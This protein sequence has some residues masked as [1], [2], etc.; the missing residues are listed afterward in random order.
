MT[1]PAPS[2]T[3]APAPRA[4]VSPVTVLGVAALGFVLLI[5][6]AFILDARRTVHH[7]Q[8]DV[9]R[10]EQ[11]LKNQE[12][13]FFTLLTQTGTSSDALAAAI[14]TYQAATTPAARRKAFGDVMAAAGS[15]APANPTDPLARRRA[16]ELAGAMNRWQVEL[17]RY[18]T[19]EEE[20]Q[21]VDASMT[22][23]LGA[24]FAWIP[25]IF[26]D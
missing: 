6:L 25:P 8:R 22:G 24:A 13:R 7:A 15:A 10:A 14:G 9:A 11:E 21:R 18:Q 2:P 16:D 4:G 20:A 12:D 23:K 17:R 1:M 19:A 3:P 5:A 26:P